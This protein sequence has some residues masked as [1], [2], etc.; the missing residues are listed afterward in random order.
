MSQTKNYYTIRYGN[1]NGE[2]KFGHIHQ[3]NTL[4][5]VL[6]RSGSEPLHYMTMDASGEDHRKHGTIFRSPG[7]FQ[8]LAGE[9]AELTSK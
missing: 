8:V 4:S 9:W 1:R 7:S 2:L 5:S 3:D 6:L